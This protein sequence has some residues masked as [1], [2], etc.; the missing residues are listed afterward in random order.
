MLKE[1]LLKE[2]EGSSGLYFSLLT[3]VVIALNVIFSIIILAYG[4]LEELS[5]RAWYVFLSFSLS[6]LAIIVFTLIFVCVKGER[7]IKAFGWNKTELKYYLL[8]LVAFTSLFFGLGNVNEI[9]VEFLSDKF[10]YEPTPIKLP[11]Y[12]V[13]NYLLVVLTVCVLPAIAEEIAM[14]GVVLNG[15]RCSSVLL[16]A[17][18]GGALFSLYHMSP[19]QTP[20]QFAVGFIFSLIAIKSGSTLPTTLAHFL[21]NFA[22]VTIEYFCPTL[23]ASKNGFMT[24]VTVLATVCFLV[25]IVLLFMDQKQEEK[26]EKGNLKDFFLH[27]T[28]GILICSVMWLAGL[29]G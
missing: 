11:E 25:V 19:M 6:P 2:D 18:I 7:V 16:R 20:Y 10:G 8:A 3:V 4:N 29:L 14:R 21:N 15:V 28:I 1:N 13:T 26:Q 9:F 27:A 24:A 5:S 12:S 17:V 22:I 23:F